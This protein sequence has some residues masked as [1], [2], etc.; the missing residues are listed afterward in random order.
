MCNIN[1][2]RVLVGLSGGLDST[3]A[4]Y[5]LKKQGHDV[6]GAA[7]IMHEYTDVS[8]AET[9]A[10]QV[11]IPF[12]TIDY[13]EAFHKNVVSRF[14]SD[15]K[16]GRT[17]NPC[18]VCNPTV[19]FDALL[20]YAVNNGFDKIATGHYAVIAKENGRY[21][22]KADAVGGKDQSYALSRLT[23]EQLKALLLPLAGMKKDTIR[24]NAA[25]LGLIAADAKDS[26]DICFIPDKD[27]ISFIE[28]ETGERYPEGDFLD[29][30]GRVIGRHK[31]I[32]RYTVGQRKGLGAFGRPMFVSRVDSENN[33]VTLVPAGEEFSGTT[34]VGEL[35]F[36]KLPPMT[37]GSLK[38]SCRVRYSAEPSPCTVTFDG[39]TATVEFENTTRAVT[40]GQSAVFYDGEDLLFSGIIQ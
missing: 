5:L 38:A 27:Y 26:Q 25:S 10:K 34:V 9:A 36:M 3:Y 40:P 6:V 29:A 20:S 11:G 4:A 33:T 16:N 24:E 22:I 35:A 28:K 8:A 30:D 39:E 12:V 21:F 13:R 7:V 19:K 1:K 14:L 17:P 18:I 15:Y 2:C 37:T 23:Q 31:G 32:I